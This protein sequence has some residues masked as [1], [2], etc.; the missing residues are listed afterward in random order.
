MILT[1]AAL[2][3]FTAM[4][5]IWQDPKTQI[6]YEYTIGDSSASVAYSER[7]VA[8][9]VAILEKI[10]VGGNEYVVTSIGDYAFTSCDKMTSIIIPDCVTS[11][12]CYAFSNCICLSSINIPKNVNFIDEYALSG[13]SCLVDVAI[14]EEVTSIGQFSF[15]GCSKLSNIKIPSKVTS[16]GQFAFFQCSKLANISIPQSVTSIGVS[17]F[18]SCPAI[19]EMKVEDGN[20]KYDSRDDCNAIIETETNCLIAGCRNTIIPNSVTDIGNGAFAGCV[21][22]SAINIPAGVKCIGDKAFNACTELSAINI[23]ASVK[24]IGDNAFSYCEELNAIT[25]PASVTNIGNGIF[26]YCK[27]LTEINV[28]S[29]N[30]MYDSRDN[31]NAI[32]ETHTNTLVAGC[33]VTHIPNSVKAIGNEAFLGFYGLTNINIPEGVISIGEK[34]FSSCGLERIRIPGS[35]NSIG[36]EAFANCNYL[37]SIIS[38]IQEPFNIQENTFPSY[39]Y[40]SAILYVPQNTRMKY[41]YVPS[42]KK[43]VRI[44]EMEE[45]YIEG[46][47]CTEVIGPQNYYNLQGQRLVG[48][49]NKG[50]YVNNG[51]VILVK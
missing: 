42:W 4:A 50:M 47:G 34:A 36:A 27:I 38:L 18:S 29:G 17:A 3:P 15:F 7:A 49:A 9:D 39:K 41:K 43:F 40:S 33:P 31:C 37:E 25:I 13:C 6:K 5:D 22:L 20:P 14:P 10:T 23:P 45:T 44:E 46:Y 35:V 19:K 8:G 28:E 21:K 2:L 30:C 24:S 26:A 51:R 48:K 1:L 32:I 11:I 12:G 16:I